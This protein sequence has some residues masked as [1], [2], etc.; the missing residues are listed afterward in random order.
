MGAPNQSFVGPASRSKSSEDSVPSARICSSTRF[1]T[2]AS[3]ASTF[4]ARSLAT[5]NHANSLAGTS[6][7]PL[8]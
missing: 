1:A 7:S 3:S 2:S 4:C 6:E 8:L 5:R